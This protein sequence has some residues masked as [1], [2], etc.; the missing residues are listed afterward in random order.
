MQRSRAKLGP[1]PQ[2]KVAA[3]TAHGTA[4]ALL[5]EIKESVAQKQTH[6]VQ[7]KYVNLFLPPFF[8]FILNLIF[9]GFKY[10]WFY[11]CL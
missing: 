5:E 1:K 6:N 9:I 8:I 7:R 10:L 4:F 2:K 11:C 3:K